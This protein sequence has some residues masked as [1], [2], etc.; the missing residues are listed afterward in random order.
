MKG[1]ERALKDAIYLIERAK[2]CGMVCDE[3]EDIV[4]M[5]LDQLDKINVN[6]VGV[7]STKERVRNH[8]QAE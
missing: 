1:A 6:Y 3:Y 5:L 2:A 7:E 8:E 4:G